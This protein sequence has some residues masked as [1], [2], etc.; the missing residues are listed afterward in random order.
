M[1]LLWCWILAILFMKIVYIKKRHI[2][3]SFATW[4]KVK[5]FIGIPKNY[6]FFIYLLFYFIWKCLKMRNDLISKYSINICQNWKILIF[7]EIFFVHSSSFINQKS[8]QRVHCFIDD[9]NHIFEAFLIASWQGSIFP[10][11]HFLTI[12]FWYHWFLVL[13]L[14]QRDGP[15]PMKY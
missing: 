7:I 5:A 10:A 1:K 4:Y 9:F 2:W 15:I 12:N 11:G 8:E 13:M 3:Y 14:K 6:D